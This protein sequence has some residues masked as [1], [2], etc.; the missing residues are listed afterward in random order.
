MSH[1]N[2][3][4]RA[5]NQPP[6][7]HLF[8]DTVSAYQRTAAIRA[9]IELDVF[10]AIA[11]GSRRIADLAE[12]CSASQ[13]GLRILCDYLTVVGFLVKHQ[14]GSEDARYELTPDSALFLD[15][16]SPAYMGTV[17]EFLCSPHI[18]Q[19][20]ADPAA[21]VRKGTRVVDEQGTIAPEHPVWVQFARAMAPMTYL[22]AQLMAS[23]IPVEPGKPVRLL[24]IAAGHGIYGITMAQ[25]HP[26]VH[27]TAVDWPQVLELAQRNADAAG[28]SDRYQRLPGSAFDVQLGEGYDIVL[29]TN[30]LHHFDPPTCETMLRRLHAAM[31]PGGR[32]VTLEIVPNADRVSPPAA[33]TFSFVMLASTPAGDAYTLAEL[34][35]MLTNSG[36][37]GTTAFPVPGGLSTVLIS[38]K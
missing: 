11:K 14:D 19:A 10:S 9:A 31:A 28:I 35:R 16:A 26:E 18:V 15:R 21:L 38:Q 1:T 32:L 2:D 27:V 23:I 17:I 3:D 5:Q 25:R 37:S 13:R 30:F 24:D 20:F 36:F 4:P 6:S 33:A 12:A 7:P 34:E 22:P 8:F 29:L